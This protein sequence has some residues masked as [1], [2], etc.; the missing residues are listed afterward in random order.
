[1][2]FP[3]Q[4][5]RCLRRVWT[6]GRRNGTVSGAQGASHSC[7]P[8][9]LG[10]D[11]GHESRE[12]LVLFLLGSDVSRSPFGIQVCSGLNSLV[13]HLFL[14]SVSLF[15]Y[16]VCSSYIMLMFFSLVGVKHA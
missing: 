16:G 1:M 8:P 4:P 5:P 13:S 11:Y 15:L 12:Y 14:L 9:Q 3:R 10:I 7:P 6:G 2:A